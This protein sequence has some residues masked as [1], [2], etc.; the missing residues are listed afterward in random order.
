MMPLCYMLLG[1]KSAYKIFSRYLVL[2]VWVSC[3]QEW[4]SSNLIHLSS[5]KFLNLQIYV[6]Q[7]LKVISNYNFFKYFS[8]SFSFFF[9][10][11]IS[12]THMIDLL[13]WPLDPWNS[14]HY[15]SFLSFLFFFYLTF[16]HP[17]SL[18]HFHR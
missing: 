18:I 5:L 12:V 6:F 14:V 16:I 10:W 3:D 13:H 1:S 7:Y 4:F 11:G 17:F 8:A 9:L 15:L 2:V